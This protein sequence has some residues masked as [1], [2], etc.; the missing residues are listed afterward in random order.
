MGL[1]DFTDLDLEIE[2]V[3]RKTPH[4]LDN[5]KKCIYMYNATKNQFYLSERE[6]WEQH[7]FIDD[8]WPE[9]FLPQCFDDSVGDCTFEYR[10][11]GLSEPCGNPDEARSILNQIGFAEIPCPFG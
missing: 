5:N 1:E 8:W 10:P 6:Y 2:Q 4:L 11:K 3:R 9:V 7:H